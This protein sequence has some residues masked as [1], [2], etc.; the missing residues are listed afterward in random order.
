[1]KFIITDSSKAMFFEKNQSI[2]QGAD[3]QQLFNNSIYQY[4]SVVH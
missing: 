2:I 4:C 3:D 1:V